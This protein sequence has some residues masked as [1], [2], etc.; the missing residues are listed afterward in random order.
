MIK[1]KCDFFTNILTLFIKSSS[2]YKDKKIQTFMQ[3][4]LIPLR[5]LDRN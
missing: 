1:Q 4:A 2:E 3:K 5:P